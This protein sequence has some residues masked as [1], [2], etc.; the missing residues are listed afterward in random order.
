VT[1]PKSWRGYAFAIIA[2]T[3]WATIGLFGKFLFR[4][5][6][7]PITIV[8]LRAIIAATTLGFALA[9]VRPTLLRISSKDLVSFAIYGLFGVALN[10]SCYFL[11]LQWTTM[12]TAAILLYTY[13][14]LVVLGAYIFLNE[15]LERNKIM[16][17]II[18]L[19]GCFFVAQGYDIKAIR[20][21]LPGVLFS[22]GAS[23][24]MASY[25]IY[26][27]RFV[28]RYS[29]WTVTFYGIGFGAVALTLMQITKLP[30]SISY[31]WQAWCLILGL[32]WG[33]TLLAYSLFTLSLK[34]IE[35]GRAS[36]IATLEPALAAFLA[37]LVLH[38]N[39][40]S[41]Q[42]GGGAMILGSVLLLHKRQLD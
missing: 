31:P 30:S 42:W 26:G 1:V 14:A 3:L 41:L 35:A 40:T 22:L 28:E 20:I 16:A 13:P 18:A 34:Y 36:I 23:A 9:I 27:K 5:A 7:D 17:L 25:C 4:Y 38:E 12:T 15:R 21:N 39:T 33:P 10:Y 19:I 8:T 32:A 6:L 11:A 29:S 37:Y 2:A 24:T